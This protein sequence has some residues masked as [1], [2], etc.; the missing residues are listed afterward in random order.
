VTGVKIQ[1]SLTIDAD[2]EQL[3]EEVVQ[4]ACARRLLHPLQLFVEMHYPLRG[5]AYNL[6]LVASPFI[7]L[8]AGDRNRSAALLRLL[9][10]DEA[11]HHLRARIA[12]ESATL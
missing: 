1:R 2:I 11:L 7:Q 3:I 6:S 5:V 8:F 10:S 4:W 9:E 12:E